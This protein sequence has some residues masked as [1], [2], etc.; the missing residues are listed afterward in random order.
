MPEYTPPYLDRLIKIRNPADEPVTP[1]DSAGRPINPPD[2]GNEVFAARRDQTPFTEIA[3][4]VQVRTGRS[5]FTI[6]YRDGIAPDAVV[7][8]QGGQVFYLVGEPVKRGGVG[9]EIVEQYLELHC[10]TKGGQE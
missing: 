5:V 10:E 3:E 7:V 6:Y 2:W 8:D 1:K 4:G 9:G